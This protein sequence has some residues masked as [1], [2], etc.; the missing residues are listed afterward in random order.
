MNIFIRFSDKTCFYSETP[1]NYVCMKLVKRFLLL[2]TII[3]ILSAGIIKAQGLPEDFINPPHEFSI[4]PFWFWN[5]TLKDEEII[6]QIADF[7]E[8]GVY[9][10]VIH[11]RIGLPENVK[12]LSAEMIHSM[13]VA[14]QEA[15][16]R[17]M[18]VILYDEGM[19]PS[20]SSSGQVVA[21]NPEYAARG[22]AKIDLKPGE[23]P[24]LQGNK[25]LI[26]IIDRPNGA[27]VAI[28]DQPSGGNIRGLHY[29]GEGSQQL[30]EES[31]P[32][33]DILNPDAVTCFMELVYDR[34]ANEFG[35]YFGTTITGIFTDEPSPLGR[36]GVSGVVP[37]NIS[38]LPQ[39]KEILG[40]DITPFLSDLW[41]DDNSDSKKHRIDYNRAVNI[42]LE[43]NYYKRLGK[44][45]KD[46]GISLMG[47]PAGS[48][49][50]GAEKY[51]QIPGQDIVWRYVE[52]GPKALEGQN[53]TVA[54]CASSAM[55]HLGLRRNSDELYG[56]YGH[57]FTYDEMTW[58]AFWCFVRGQNLLIPHAFFYSIRGPRFDERPPDVGP[59]ASWWSKYREYA[60]ACR[61]LSWLN[62]DSKQVCDLA[63]LCE[64][65]YLPDKSAK[66]CYQHQLD[67]NY[68]EIRH[69]W[70]DAKIDSKGV[71]IAGM[72]YNVIVIDSLS[73][74]PQKAIPFLKKLAENGRLIINKS[75][76][77][78]SLFKGSVVYQS[79]DNMLAEIKKMILPDFG[80]GTP[81]RDIRYRHV[82][83]G[84]N[85][86]YIIFNE[87]SDVLTKLI[88]SV[89]GNYQFL[90]PSTGEAV[91]SGEDEIVLF[92]PYELKIL[93]IFN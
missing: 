68:L 47:H 32:A 26:T 84:N 67:F 34:Y 81:S 53:S 29:I 62:T 48:M 79:H 17:K 25:K 20:G 5:D 14:I 58:L 22:I 49:D 55:I 42:C 30:K 74:M 50:I 82:V 69:L 54:K 44:W 73:D 87:G 90:N 72:N 11:P 19:Y 35:K 37:G 52:P 83:K 21:R 93:R 7:G 41:Y 39:I 23:T 76:N 12:W 80:L 88:T 33:G 43:E 8:H 31:P 60:D 91:K 92:K 57:N 10:F 45:C 36:S 71:H 66:T 75:S 56:A 89:K 85:H 13:N 9:G 27:R 16:R 70:E 2:S 61:R 63:I 3:I 64:A 1:K 40:Y 6:R 15:S 46:H 38:L 51:F 77:Y 59:N 86:Y 4:M 28:V 18:Y 24:D 78:S 65:S